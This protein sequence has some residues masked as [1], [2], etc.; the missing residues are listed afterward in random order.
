M[1]HWGTSVHHGSPKN[2]H[3]QV[4]ACCIGVAKRH[5]VE[6]GAMNVAAMTPV[7]VPT[8]SLAIHKRYIDIGSDIYIY[9]IY[10]EVGYIHAM[11]M[12]IYI[13]KICW[14]PDLILWQ[15]SGTIISSHVCSW[16]TASLGSF[17]CARGRRKLA[18]RMKESDMGI[19]PRKVENWYWYI[20]IY[21]WYTYKYI[22]LGYS[23]SFDRPKLELNMI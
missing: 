11:E 4:H 5:V 17:S 20:Y 15:F 2:D 18:E 8:S 22:R 13:S 23:W 7:R 19:S 10:K 21:R 3:G 12:T 16:L 1:F 9:C 14:D 6:V